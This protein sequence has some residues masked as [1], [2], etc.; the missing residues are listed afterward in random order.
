[1]AGYLLFVGAP[2]GQALL[3]GKHRKKE[4]DAYIAID[5][6]EV[7]R[8]GLT[9]DPYRTYVWSESSLANIR[10]EVEEAVS[11]WR[12]YEAALTHAE[13]K[14]ESNTEALSALLTLINRAKEQ[15]GTVIYRGD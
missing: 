1:M 13:R 5:S 10:E 2:K 14:A 3:H 11:R 7:A 6:L 4:P 12:A 9:H 15:D 8:L